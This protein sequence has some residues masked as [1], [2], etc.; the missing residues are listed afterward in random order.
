MAR[1]TIRIEL[2][3]GHKVYEH[4]NHPVYSFLN[5]GMETQGFSRSIDSGGLKQLPRG[6][7]TINGEFSCAQVLRTVKKICETTEREY[8][9]VV[10]KTVECL[11]LGLKPVTQT[12]KISRREVTVHKAKVFQEDLIAIVNDDKKDFIPSIR[13][14]VGADELPARIENITANLQ[15]T[16]AYLN[17]IADV[18]KKNRAVLAKTRAIMESTRIDNPTIYGQPEQFNSEMRM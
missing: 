16:R 11:C 4:P 3:T 18:V 7:Y 15:K 1:F 12:L 6:E 14:R 13:K 9:I 8:A 10:C 5:Q 17:G 2:H